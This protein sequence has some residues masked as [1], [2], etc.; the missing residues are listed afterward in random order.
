M[1]LDRVHRQVLTLFPAP[2]AEEDPHRKTDD[3]ILSELFDNFRIEAGVTK[4]L[5]LSYMGNKFL[6]N[7]YED[8]AYEI[9]RPVTHGTL[10]LL[11]KYQIWPYYIS[12]NY[13]V[14]YNDIDASMFKM[15]NS[16]VNEYAETLKNG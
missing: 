4:G 10:L 2:D 15:S 8:Y 16:D 11:D 14:F 9:K 3:Q 12:K 7:F 1:K 6:K 13:I 5:R